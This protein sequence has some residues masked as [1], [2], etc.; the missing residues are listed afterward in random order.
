MSGLFLRSELCDRAPTVRAQSQS[1]DLRQ[2]LDREL[3]LSE[4]RQGSAQML[5]DVE[6]DASGALACCLVQA[7][8]QRASSAYPSWKSSRCATTTSRPCPLTWRCCPLSRSS[9]STAPAASAPSS[10]PGSSPKKTWSRTATRAR[11]SH[12]C[13]LFSRRVSVSC[14]ARHLEARTS[15]SL[16]SWRQRDGLPPCIN[17]CCNRFSHLDCDLA[18]GRAQCSP[19]QVCCAARCDGRQEAGG[20]QSRAARPWCRGGTVVRRAEGAWC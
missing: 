5:S 4:V 7:S 3:A 10:F 15:S 19:T 18:Y 20:G 6:A 17:S 8:C 14:Q 16:S 11:S 12:V 13:V 2:S 1:S 9:T